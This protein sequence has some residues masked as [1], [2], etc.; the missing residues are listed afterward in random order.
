MITTFDREIAQQVAAELKAA[1]PD[2][3]WSEGYLINIIE[4]CCQGNAYFYGHHRAFDAYLVKRS[5]WRRE[6]PNCGLVETV[7]AEAGEFCS[8]VC[9]DE[10][11]RAQP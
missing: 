2:N 7:S 9:E 11:H 5:L 8:Q 1:Y 10:Y 3:Q 6:C 4:M